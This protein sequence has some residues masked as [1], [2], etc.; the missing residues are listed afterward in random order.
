MRRSPIKPSSDTSPLQVAPQLAAF[1]SKN[2][3]NY[4]VFYAKGRETLA[5]VTPLKRAAAA[6]ARE[7]PVSSQ[8]SPPVLHDDDVI[9]GPESDRFLGP[10]ND[11]M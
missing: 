1:S 9:D 5:S 8:S 2:R 10:V 7:L 4:T 11:Y 6:A 3:L